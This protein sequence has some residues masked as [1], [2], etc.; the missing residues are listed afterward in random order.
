MCRASSGS[1]STPLPSVGFDEAVGFLRPPRAG[2]VPGDGYLVAGEGRQDGVD[3]GPCLLDLV[4]A[5]EQG[6]VADERVEQ[7]ALI[8]LR[9]LFQEGSAV[10]EVHRD[11]AHPECLAGDLGP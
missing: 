9:R 4:A 10:E 6:G 8:S 11:R 3:D 5:Y 2:V 1:G 7:E